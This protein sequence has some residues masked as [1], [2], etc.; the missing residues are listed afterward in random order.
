MLDGMINRTKPCKRCSRAIEYNTDHD[1]CPD[2]A[3]GKHKK[4]PDDNV[5]SS[6]VCFAC[7]GAGCAKC[8]TE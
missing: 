4:T 1:L 7:G 6:R 3:S 5:Y 8:P 2:C